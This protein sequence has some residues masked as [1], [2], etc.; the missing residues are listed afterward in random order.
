MDNIKDL[1]DVIAR[2]GE[3]FDCKQAL[4]WSESITCVL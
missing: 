4:R 1:L 3:V 2:F